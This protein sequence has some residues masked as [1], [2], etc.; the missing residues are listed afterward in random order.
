MR[1]PGQ[2]TTDKG[3]GVASS[4]SQDIYYQRLLG[5]VKFRSQNSIG[6][7][8]SIEPME[9]IDFGPFNLISFPPSNY[10]FKLRPEHVLNRPQ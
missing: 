4:S 8:N 9:R 2:H 5:N 6:L 3:K 7:Q 10:L 1:P